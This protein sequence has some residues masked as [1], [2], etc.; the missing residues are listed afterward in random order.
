MA[1]IA[2]VFGVYK[3]LDDLSVAVL[4]AEPTIIEAAAFATDYDDQRHLEVRGR[5]ATAYAHVEPGTHRTHVERDLVYVNVPI[6]GPA[7]TP[8]TPVRVAATFG[9]LPAVDVDDWARDAATLSSVRGLVRPVPLADA[10][11]RFA[12]LRVE[13][14]LVVVN[15]GTAPQVG[16]SVL[17]LLIA[18]GGVFVS[19]SVLG[20]LWREHSKRR[21]EGGRAEGAERR[22]PAGGV[23]DEDD[24]D[25]DVRTG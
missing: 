14:A 3:G 6:V 21:F 23:F 12:P 7:W 2:T 16:A 4:E 11:E 8:D 20:E 18:V 17:F 1:V 10:D 24:G 22:V 13:E 5:V 19:V 9:P 25:E 15:E